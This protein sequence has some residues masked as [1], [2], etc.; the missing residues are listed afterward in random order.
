MNAFVK[1]PPGTTAKMLN[2]TIKMGEFKV[3]LKTGDVICEGK[4]CKKV[5]ASESFWNIERD[6]E[7]ST[8]NV[9]LEKADGKNWWNCLL[10]GDIEIDTQKVEPENSKLSDLD[11]E[12]R[13]TVEKM[14]F[15]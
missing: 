12:T 9:Q 10:L 14:M 13:S 15:D 4:W 11:A 3:A 2:V 1:L 8:L 6:G 7:K 5:N